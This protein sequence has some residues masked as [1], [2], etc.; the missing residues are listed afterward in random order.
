MAPQAV[1]SQVPTHPVLAGRASRFAEVVGIVLLAL[2]AARIAEVIPGASKVRPVFLAGLLGGAFLLFEAGVPAI[3]ARLQ[4]PV[5]RTGLAYAGWAALTAPFAL[6]P[7]QAIRNIYPMFVPG[8]VLVL[9]VSLSPP[10]LS[11]LDR[12][13]RGLAL[14]FGALFLSVLS[15]AL[16]LK[17]RLYSGGSLD[18]NDLASCAAIAF[19]LAVMQASRGGW[20]WRLAGAAVAVLSAYM[21]VQ[22]GSRGGTLAFAAAVLVLILHLRP[23]TRLF[24]AAIVIVVLPFV[25]GVAPPTFRARV[26]SLTSLES[27]YNSF[28]YFGRRA[29]WRRG[30]RYTLQNPVT[31]VGLEN[32]GTAEGRALT[33][34]GQRGKWSASHSAYIQA[35]AELGLIG[36]GIFLLLLGRAAQA[37]RRLARL[38]APQDSRPEFIAALAGFAV[39]AAFLSH[40]YFWGLWGLLAFAALATEI[41]PRTQSHHAVLNGRG[42]RSR[43]G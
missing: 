19:P 38:G 40:A 31:G 35:F 25:W 4:N 37:F 18:P 6:W 43:R 29:I 12:T 2:I 39:G 13:S 20:F 16:V 14:A 34:E 10:T 8:L 1:A 36:G 23:R 3:R 9:V 32:F 7:G 21:L 33:S 30:V 41:L 22:T 42:A 26:A 27:D 24:A 17:G 15:D 28:D 11:T 5:V